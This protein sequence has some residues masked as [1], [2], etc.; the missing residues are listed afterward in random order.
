ML[1]S[2]NS[3]TYGINERRHRKLVGISDTVKKELQQLLFLIY[4]AVGIR[5]F[6]AMLAIQRYVVVKIMNM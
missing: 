4:G 3:M 5:I 6:Y 2:E 1:K